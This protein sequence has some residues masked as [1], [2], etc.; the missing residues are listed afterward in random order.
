[1]TDLE[2]QA[3]IK[4]FAQKLT[5]GLAPGSL[6]GQLSRN[7]KDFPTSVREGYKGLL[8]KAFLGLGAVSL[9]QSPEHKGSILGGELGYAASLG[10]TRGMP[11]LV[12]MPLGIGLGMLGGRVG[13]VFDRKVPEQP[14]MKMG[15]SDRVRARSYPPPDE[16]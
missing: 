9:A 15:A 11:G 13:S 8:P 2:K 6:K 14:Q 5:K 3:F 16:Q 4:G 12:G 10:L 7:L 1:M